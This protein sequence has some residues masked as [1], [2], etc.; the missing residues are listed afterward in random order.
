MNETLPAAP[1]AAGL[2]HAY[3]CESDPRSS[4]PAP[5]PTGTPGRARGRSTSAADLSG[6]EYLRRILRALAALARTRSS[7][8][9][10]AS[11]SYHRRGARSSSTR[12]RKPT[13]ASDLAR[14]L[15]D[16]AAFVRRYVVMTPSQ[17][18]AVALWVVHTHAFEAAEA[19]AYLHVTSAERESGKSRL[20]RSARARR[21]AAIEDGRNNGGSPRTSCRE[22]SA[23]VDA[24]RRNRQR[25]QARRRV[26]R[27]AVLGILNDGYRR[28]GRTLL[29]LPP[30]WE[31]SF[32]RLRTEGRRRHRRSTRHAPVAVDPDRAVK[33]PAPRERIERFRRRDV[34]ER[35]EP[36]R[37]SI[38]SLAELHTAALAKARPELPDELGDRAM[39]VWEPLIAIA[40]LAGGEWPQFARAAAVELSAAGASEDDSLGVQLLA[41]VH[42]PSP[43]RTSSGWRV[44]R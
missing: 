37:L 13:T 4:R 15:D 7:S 42:P 3:S 33:L 29:C 2:A 28:G 17:V 16:L 40:D 10:V 8:P 23:A 5:M 36:I 44:R 27:H 1:G 26:C 39:D 31:P 32:L 6:G 14:V 18:S 35:A 25:L 12:G 38:E 41:G 20:L 24:A 21:G 11:T 9:A 30:K 22:G 19:T 34:E 43:A